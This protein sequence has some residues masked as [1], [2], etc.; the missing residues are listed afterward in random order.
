[1][2]FT[3]TD[4]ERLD[5]LKKKSLWG[6]IM[7][8]KVSNG[9]TQ[10]EVFIKLPRWCNEKVAKKATENI[11]ENLALTNSKLII[12]QHSTLIKIELP[13]DAAHPKEN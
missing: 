2:N 13:D 7:G 8:F 6:R 1:M 4:S 10:N 9:L 12:T 3:L 11:R 5:K